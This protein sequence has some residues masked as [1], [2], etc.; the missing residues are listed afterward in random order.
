MIVECDCG[1][2]LR[3]DDSKAGLR[4]RCPGCQETLTVKP[5]GDSGS[6]SRRSPGKSDRRRSRKPADD[7]FEPYEDDEDWDVDDDDGWDDDDYDDRPRRRSSRGGGR[8]R[9]RDSERSRGRRSR[10]GDRSRGSRRGGRDRDRGDGR[11]GH[12]PDCG[13]R[14]Y[15]KISYTL[16]G[17]I[18]GPALFSH[19]KCLD[20]RSTFNSK[21]GRSNQT[22]ITIFVIVS[23]VIGLG[24]VGIALCA[25]AGAN[26]R[27]VEVSPELPPA[28]VASLEAEAGR[29]L[30]EDNNTAESSDWPT[31]CML[32]PHGIL[33]PKS[34][35]WRSS[36]AE[37]CC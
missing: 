28:P 17:G 30:P 5:A 21:T 26:R 7:E 10:G 2:K 15:K 27:R 9:G 24:L 8:G 22:A 32:G 19:V 18:I 37:R 1:K 35:A 11:P 13:S 14:D 12:C 25:G 29:T 4:I 36:I 3:I 31:N 20:C 6:R 23:G 33:A 16:W 34:T